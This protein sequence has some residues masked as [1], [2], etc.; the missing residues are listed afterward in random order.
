MTDAPT[1]SPIESEVYYPQRKIDEARD[2]F[3]IGLFSDDGK[4]IYFSVFNSMWVDDTEVN[5]KEVELRRAGKVFPKQYAELWKSCAQPFSVIH[6]VADYVRWFL[7][8]G[9]NAL[10]AGA[11]ARELAPWMLEPAP[12]IM[13][14]LIGFNNPHN[15]PKEAFNKAPTAKVRMRVIERDLYRCKICDRRPA[16]HTDIELHVHHI[17]PFV[18]S[19]LTSEE[20]L[21]TLCHTCHRGLN[22]HFRPQLFDLVSPT[23]SVASSNYLE[24]VSLYQKAMQEDG[25]QASRKG[26]RSNRPPSQ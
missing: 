21:I 13:V 3:A 24:R 11:I 20:N 23:E 26:R 16:D 22:P 15:I 14:G 18:P 4:K 7:L 9:G 10:I 25:F 1:P 17:R 19:G 2:Y 12:A 6:T 8:I 5:G